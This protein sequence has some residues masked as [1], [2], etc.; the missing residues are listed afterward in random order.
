MMVA[1]LQTAVIALVTFCGKKPN[2]GSKIGYIRLNDVALADGSMTT[3]DD[4][5]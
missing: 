2:G 4:L 1:G 3:C 5:R